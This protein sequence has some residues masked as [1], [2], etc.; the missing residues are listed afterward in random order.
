MPL[1]ESLLTSQ[2]EGTHKVSN[3][4][5]V[6]LPVLDF[7]TSELHLLRV[8]KTRD[9]GFVSETLAFDVVDFVACNHAI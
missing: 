9:F 5:D 7:V 8:L 6:N 2:S 1:W 4:A 3:T